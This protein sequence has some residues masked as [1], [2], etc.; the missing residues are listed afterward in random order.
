MSKLEKLRSYGFSNEVLQRFQAKSIET[1]IPIEVVL[2]RCFA[3]WIGLQDCKNTAPS[4]QG[5]I[6]QEL[7]NYNHKLQTELKTLSVQ[8]NSQFHTINQLKQNNKVIKESNKSLKKSNKFLNN[9]IKELKH[10][11]M[12]FEQSEIYTL[13]KS[14]LDALRSKDRKTLNQNGLDF[15]EFTL[16]AINLAEDGLAE[17]E[18]EIE[19]LSKEL[20]VAQTFME[21]ARDKSPYQFATWMQLTRTFSR[22]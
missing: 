11:L 3:V 17:L 1:G 4:S 16:E 10:K 21:I 8:T 9:Q 2:I 12:N 5:V 7:I 22:G 6:L 14:I 20:I 19:R 18:D 13:G 15:K